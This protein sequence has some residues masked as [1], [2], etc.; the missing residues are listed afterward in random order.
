[1]NQIRWKLS[2]EKASNTV[3]AIHQEHNIS[4]EQAICKREEKE[5]ENIVDVG[6]NAM[7]GVSEK[8]TTVQLQY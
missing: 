8:K 2:R 1:M 7:P 3:K 4:Q 5:L 6:A